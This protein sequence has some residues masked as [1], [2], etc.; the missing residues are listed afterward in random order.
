MCK[1]AQGYIR[2]LPASDT[3]PRG[4][5]VIPSKCL[6]RPLADD[7]VWVWAALP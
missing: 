3:F 2:I 5:A 1:E 7:R 6:R 4:A